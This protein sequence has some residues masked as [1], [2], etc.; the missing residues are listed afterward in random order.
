[1]DTG[2]CFEVLMDE[3]CLEY[4]G[5]VGRLVLKCVLRREIVDRIYVTEIWEQLTICCEQNTVTH[6]LVPKTTAN[7]SLSRDLVDSKRLVSLQ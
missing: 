1:M 5:L 6:P 4:L 7:F 3:D 2:F